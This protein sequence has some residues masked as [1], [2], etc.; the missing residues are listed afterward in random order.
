MSPSYRKN[1]PFGTNRSPLISPCIHEAF[2][3]LEETMIPVRRLTGGALVAVLALG[4]CQEEATTG[5]VVAEAEL[6]LHPGP[7]A[8]QRTFKGNFAGT[9]ATGAQ[10]G[11]QPWQVMLYVQGEGQATH[12]G[13]TKL[14]L[15]A[16]WDI[17]T[18]R[19]VGSVLAVY[20]AASGDEL[21]MRVVGTYSM[22]GTDYEVY[23]GTGRFEGAT[24]LLNVTGE[25]YPDFTW[26][27]EAVGWIA[28]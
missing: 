14:D 8:V 28:Y 18:Y 25:Q 17:T 12:L 1:V 16:C 10:C 20:T 9:M 24:G 13:E 2:I 7:E 11:D 6:S 19:P 15:V 3:E 26:T 27:T 23:G 21:W 22:A 4:G 5:P